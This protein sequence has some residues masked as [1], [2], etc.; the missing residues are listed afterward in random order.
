MGYITLIESPIKTCP[1]KTCYFPEP[2]CGI[3]LNKI[4]VKKVMKYKVRSQD[5][6]LP[7]PFIHKD[8]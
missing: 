3:W 8:F 1:R 6:G 4:G 7:I 2:P 5:D